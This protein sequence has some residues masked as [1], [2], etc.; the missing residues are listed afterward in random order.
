[1]NNPIWE[2]QFQKVNNQLAESGIGDF[3]DSLDFVKHS[4][5][6]L[7]E[8]NCSGVT[9]FAKVHDVYALVSFKAD[10]YPMLDELLGLQG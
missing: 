6:D 3:L 7:K 2:S 1:M 10:V 5:N 8:A 9:V 4:M